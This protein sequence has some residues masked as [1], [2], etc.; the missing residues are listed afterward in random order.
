[1]QA[2]PRQEARPARTVRPFQDVP[3]PPPRQR[4]APGRH[5]PDG[6]HCEVP[7]Q[8][9]HPDR[10]PHPER[11]YR[12]SP[13]DQQRLTF[14]EAALAKK[15]THSLPSGPGQL[16]VPPISPRTD[17][18]DPSHPPTGTV[19]AGTDTPGTVGR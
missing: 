16:S 13:L 8:E 19:S 14:G 15:S 12:P 6:D 2:I 3:D 11:M 10:E 9:G 17:Q 4:Q 1:M 5:G 7:I 18:N